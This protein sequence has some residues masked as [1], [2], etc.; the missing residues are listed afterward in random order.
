MGQTP[1]PNY[2]GRKLIR[3]LRALR[4]QARL[5][6]T[7]AGR[8]AHIELKKLSRLE[9][10]QLPSY[11]ELCAILDVYGVLSGDWAPFVELW[12][13]AKRP[14]WWREFGV[15]DP[16]YIRMEDEATVM[17]EFR[18][19][20]LPD[21]LQTETYA[22]AVLTNTGR[23]RSDEIVENQVAIRMRRQRRLFTD[24]K[25]TLHTLIH[26]PALYQGADAEQLSRLVEHA[27]LSNVTLQIVPR[28]PT[29]HVGLHGS[30]ALLTFPDRI[31]PDIAFADTLAGLAETQHPDQVADV[32]RA[33]DLVTSLALSPQ[34]SVDHINQLIG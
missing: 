10:A 11:H 13:L 4:K 25:L 17:Y 8:R 31:E 2:F 12:E 28:T 21:L 16:R 3:D 15:R 9:T 1:Q 19:G 22:R 27:R 18:L 34:D 6:Q 24:P 5:S 23:S 33:I 30:V 29:V 14:P 7:E 32:R 20:Y 26:E